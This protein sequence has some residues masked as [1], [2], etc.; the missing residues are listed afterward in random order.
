MRLPLSSLLLDRAVGW[1]QGVVSRLQETPHSLSDVDIPGYAAIPDPSTTG[2]TSGGVS[3][4][5]ESARLAAIAEALE[6]HAATRCPLETVDTDG[7]RWPI[8]T[9]TLHSPAQRAVPGFPFPGYRD[10][11]YTHAWTLPDN[12]PVQVPAG[13]LSL[14]ARHGLPSTS[15][16]LAAGPSATAALTAAVSELIERDA[17]TTVWLHGLAPT[18]VA[19]PDRLADPVTALGGEIT[20]FDLTPAYSPYPVAAIAG[21]LP[22][23]GVARPTLGLACKPT[24]REAVDKAW[25]EWC[26]GTV[27]IR[28]RLGDTGPLRPDQVT[29]FDKHAVYYTH[30]DEWADLPLWRGKAGDPPADAPDRDLRTLVDALT[31]ADIRLAYRDL[32]TPELAAVGLHCVR[33]LSPNL[34]P[35]HSDHR[36]PHVGGRAAEVSWRYP[37]LTAHTAFPSPYPHPLG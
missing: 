28:V 37:E 31:G 36:W 33:A 35:L 14:D 34:T 5:P 18:R 3:L 17:L 10:P 2:G 21:T 26:Q 1:R 32:T 6:R 19:V 12:R 13:L 25:A 22:V 20:A 8:D 27:F 23:A 16:G 4:D 7:P 15:S 29:D 11:E 30:A 24:W 9:F